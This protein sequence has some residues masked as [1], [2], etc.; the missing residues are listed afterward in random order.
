[1]T[2]MSHLSFQNRGCE[3]HYWYREGT[4]DRYV[5]LFHGGG[6]DHRM[7]DEQLLI[8]D[9][10]FHVIAWDARGHGLSRLPKEIRFD[11]E[12][13]IDDCLKLYELHGINTAIIIGQS[14]GGNLAQEIAYRYPEKAER[15]VIIDS[16]RNTATL[17]RIEN[18]LVKLTK[19][20]MYCY[21]LK[22]LVRQS[23]D[24]CSNRED[25]RLYVREC[26]SQYSRKDFIDIITAT[27]RC[28]H[29]DSAF[30]FKQPV[31]LL[32]GADD[33]SGII[34]KTVGP[35]AESDD[36][37]TLHMIDN[38]SHNS[39]QDSPE[40]VNKLIADFIAL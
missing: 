5:L 40:V 28:L 39:N 1:M 15:L 20:I 21:P 35:W 4:G 30:R 10:T 8:F 16:M 12:D 14:M 32:C 38:A 11:F 31:L 6:I 22:T 23:A 37:I 24:A 9:E 27:T 25:V 33:Q 18:L 36:R 13:M 19:P 26:L 3:I 29:D 34:K 2:T 7:F 17:S